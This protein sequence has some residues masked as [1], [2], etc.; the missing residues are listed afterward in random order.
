MLCIPAL[1]RA[2]TGNFSAITNS[3]RLPVAK[4]L[5][6]WPKLRLRIFR[7]LPNVGHNSFLFFFFVVVVRLFRFIR[8]ISILWAGTVSRAGKNGEGY[9]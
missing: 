1:S 7:D 9:P 2:G 8:C 3:S 6:Y 4:T 5:T